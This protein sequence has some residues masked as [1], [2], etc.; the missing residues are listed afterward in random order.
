MPDQNY[1]IQPQRKSW[2]T[3]ALHILIWLIVFLI[4]YIFSA[5][6]QGPGHIPNNEREQ[7]LHL[8]TGLNFFWLALFYFN[9]GI[10][11]PRLVY[12]RK[13]GIYV[14]TLI[15]ILALVVCFDRFMFYLFIE[16]RP[17]SIYH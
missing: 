15:G 1:K 3:I 14:L 9:S 6:I 8:N 2:A 4:P 11:L 12:K 17:F 16:N 7:F 5:D 13:I 10:L